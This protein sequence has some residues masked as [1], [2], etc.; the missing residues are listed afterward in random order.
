MFLVGTRYIHMF[1]SYWTEI[2]GKYLEIEPYDLSIPI[3]RELEIH[4]ARRGL[5]WQ[6]QCAH[7]RIYIKR[8]GPEV[9]CPVRNC[10]ITHHP[11]HENCN[12]LKIFMNIRNFKF[13]DNLRWARTMLY[14]GFRGLAHLIFGTK[15]KGSYQ[16]TISPVPQYFRHDE[17]VWP[18][19]VF[20]QNT[21]Y[22]ILI[23]GRCHRTAA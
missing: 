1:S 18:S 12:I 10:V 13:V 8:P 16:F 22:V 15:Y 5:Y 4:N 2:E 3:L 11:H 17:R 7:P 23:V 20:G 19:Q 9:D 14:P 6:P 21:W